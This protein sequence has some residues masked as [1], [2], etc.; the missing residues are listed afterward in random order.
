MKKGCFRGGMSN[1][2]RLVVNH[3]VKVS[4]FFLFIGLIVLGLDQLTKGLVYTYLP[5]TNSFSYDYPYGGIGIFKNFLGIEF[6]INHMTNTGAAWGVLGD[7]QLALMVIRI[8]LIMGLCIYLF[9][10]NHHF[11][12]QLPLIFIIA[13]ASGNVMDFFVYGHVVDM[14]HFVLWGY[15]FPV[16]NVADSAIS[17]GIF[18]LFLLSFLDTSS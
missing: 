11:S 12:W 5:V 13:G 10:F 16:F 7:Y 18:S 3:R 6:S 8:A 9:F 17:I 14:V 1:L 2:C 15:D 4:S